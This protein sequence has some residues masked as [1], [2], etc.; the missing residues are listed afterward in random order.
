LSP[1]PAAITPT[2]AIFAPAGILRRL[3]QNYLVGAAVRNLE[4]GSKEH[5]HGQTVIEAFQSLV[6]RALWP[7]KPVAAGSPRIVTEY[8][9]ITFAAYTSVGVGQVMEFYIN[10][11]TAGVIIGFL[12]FGTLLTL[13][14]T[15]AAERLWRGDWLQFAMWFLPGLALMQAGGSLV[16]VLSSAGAG[17]LAVLFVNRFIVRARLG[18]PQP[19]GSVSVH[20]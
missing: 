15:W 6:P 8:T 17:M 16:E 3:N 1:H 2:S 4:S 5:A 13:L 14:D 11:G 19:V 10:F 9:G 20:S 18:P 7:S 12:L